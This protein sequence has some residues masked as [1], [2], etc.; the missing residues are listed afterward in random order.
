MN[1]IDQTS[2]FVFGYLLKNHQSLETYLEK[3]RLQVH[4]QHRII[5]IIH[6]DNQYITADILD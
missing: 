4:A 6:L 5:D 1:C 2:D 3:L